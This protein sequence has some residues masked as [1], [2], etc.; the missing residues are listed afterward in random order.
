MTHEAAGGQQRPDRT[1]TILELLR[2]T[3]EHFAGRGIDSARLDAECL[4]A[5]ALGV[6]RLQLYVDFEKPAHPEERARFRELVMR[7]AQDR[8]PVSQ[9][10]SER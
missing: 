9:L 3:E 4:L 2:W 6:P 1:W 10:L 5:H 7:R 8:V